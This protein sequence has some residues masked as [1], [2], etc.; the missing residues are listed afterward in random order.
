VTATLAGWG[1]TAW[2]SW[3]VFE[4]D[5]AGEAALATTP[6]LAGSYRG[7][8]AMGLLWSMER[9][10]EATSAPPI[11]ITGAF[12]LTLTAGARDGS[13]AEITLERR[14]AAPGVTRRDVHEPRAVGVLFTPASPGPHPA[15]IVLSGSGG[16]VFPATAALLASRGYAALAL[17]YFRMPGLPQGLVNIPLEYFESAIGWLRE[18]VQPRDDFVGV[19]GWSRGGELALLLGA[20]IPDV[21]A[22]VAWAASGVLFGP[23]GPSEPG[24]GGPRAA[25]THRG[26]SLPHLGQNNRTMDWSVVDQRRTP[27]VERPA[28]LTMLRDRDA[29]ERASIPV[30]RTKGPIMLISGLADD[31]WPSFDLAQIAYRRLQGYRH[32]YPFAHLSY[33][34]AGHLIGVPYTATTPTSYVHPVNGLAYSLGGDPAK[35]AAANADS[36]PKVLAFLGDARRARRVSRGAP[37]A[38][39]RLRA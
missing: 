23:V 17:G 14:L 2:R 26:R 21:S 3:A 15:V 16:G 19:L 28:Y 24:D 37:A 11:P 29:V 18:A 34:G 9:Q 36:W 6:S 22:V 27:I 38:P 10:A 13:R 25:W 7:V 30:E 20:S 12:P 4:T 39:G 8:S 35:T 5:A 1:P 31:Q 32:P 33:E